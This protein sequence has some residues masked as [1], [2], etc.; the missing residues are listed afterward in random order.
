MTPHS[1]GA[2]LATLAL[3][4]SPRTAGWSEV[5]PP[6]AYLETL[7]AGAL[8]QVNGEVVGKTPLTFAVRDASAPYRLRAAAP[9]FETLE[10]TVDGERLANGRLDLVLRPDGFGSQRRLDL[11]D[12]I[13][14]TQ[15]AAHLARARRPREALA[16]VEAALAV[17]ET[18]VAHRV[19]GEAY[20]QLGDRNRAVQE[21]SVYLT[22]QP[23]APDREVVE[24]AIEGARGDLTIPPLVKD[25]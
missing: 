23:D 19:A 11:A 5:R 13:G 2:L 20:Q 16:F 12:P 21:F 10:V 18:A 9:G 25:Q 15:A 4:C 7:P 24:K 14:L 3:A 6:E 1:R 17:G 8:L 22:M